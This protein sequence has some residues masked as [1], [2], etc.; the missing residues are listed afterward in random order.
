MLGRFRG[1][2]I[3]HITY[4]FLH[5]RLLSAL[6]GPSIEG[7]AHGGEKDELQGR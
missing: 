3:T 1:Y 5:G 2:P 4:H 7:P 6:S